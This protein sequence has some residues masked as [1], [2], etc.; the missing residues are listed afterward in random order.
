MTLGRS[1]KGRG[2]DL[3]PEPSGTGLRALL[4]SAEEMLDPSRVQVRD[5]LPLAY[6]HLL[7]F[8]RLS[9]EQCTFFLPQCTT[10]AKYNACPR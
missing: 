9:N 6:S 10:T 2:Q 8:L 1:R 7:C 3:V 5:P 4:A